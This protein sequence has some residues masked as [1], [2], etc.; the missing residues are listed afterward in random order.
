VQQKERER[1][2]LIFLESEAKKGNPYGEWMDLE[3]VKQTHS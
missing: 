3:L 1:H 2:A